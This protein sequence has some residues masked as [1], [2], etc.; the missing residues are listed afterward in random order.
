MIFGLT[1]AKANSKLQRAFASRNFSDA[2]AAYRKL[3]SKTPTDHELFNNLGIAY[4]ES[5]ALNESI[6]SFNNANRLLPA[7]THYNNLGRALLERKE[8]DAARDAFD[9]GRELDAADPQPWY[10]ITVSLREEERLDE[11]HQE[12][13]DFLRSHP[14]HG[15]GLNDLGCH[16]LDRGETD[17]AIQCFTKAV[18]SDPA[19]V[20]ARLNLIR[21]LCDAK[22]YP[23]ATPHLETLAQQGL[24]VQVHAD[25]DQVSIDLNGSPFYRTKP[26]T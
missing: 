22:R 25:N 26:S 10:N 8:Y 3:I 23:D 24:N 18:D 12:L 1:K 19:A 20:S 6:E 21:S 4:M 9:K 15:N 17:D 11:A 16:H 13:L 14:M 7:C 5:G 2:I